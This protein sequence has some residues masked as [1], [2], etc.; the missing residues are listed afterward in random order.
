MSK[1][2]ECGCGG[3]GHHEHE[4]HGGCGD[5]CG[6][7]EKA[8]IYITFEDDDKEIAC[9]VIG[10]FE[11]D[12]QE[13]IAISPENEEDG[14]EIFIYRYHENAETDDVEL[15]DIESDEEYDKVVE[16]FHTLFFGEEE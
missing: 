13:Y 7:G 15:A 16:E 11:V 10:V 6:C 14:D 12:D 5:D 3:H 4:N 8:T 9:D 1:E 2:H